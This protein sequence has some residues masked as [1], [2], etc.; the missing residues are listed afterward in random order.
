[1]HGQKFHWQENNQKLHVDQCL[2]GRCLRAESEKVDITFSL[3]ALKGATLDVVY[4]T[5]GAI[6]FL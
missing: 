1:M 6:I 2:A 3:S 5:H 4:N